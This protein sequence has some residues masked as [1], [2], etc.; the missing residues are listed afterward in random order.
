MLRTKIALNEFSFSDLPKLT[1]NLNEIINMLK[2]P[3]R[4]PYF[5]RQFFDLK[6]RIHKLYEISFELLLSDVAKHLINIFKL[7]VVPKCVW[8]CWK[9]WKI[10]MPVYHVLHMNLLN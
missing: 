10:S 4:S 9:S 5:F 8:T 6:L 7:S 3:S 1:N 2:L